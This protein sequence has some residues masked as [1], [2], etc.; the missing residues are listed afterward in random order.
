MVV[1]SKSKNQNDISNHRDL[2][3]VVGRIRE[4]VARMKAENRIALA[5]LAAI[6]LKLLFAS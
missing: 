3:N 6:I 2:W 1:E 4:D 5:L